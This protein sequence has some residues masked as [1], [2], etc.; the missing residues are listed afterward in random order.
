VILTILEKLLNI[1]KLIDTKKTR[2]AVARWIEELHIRVADPQNSVTTLSGG[3]QQRVVLAKWIAT[4]PKVLLLDSPTVG[5]D[6]AAKSGIYDIVK[7]LASEGMGIVLISDEVS[8]VLYN[9][10]RILLMRK[11]SI[12]GEFFPEHTTEPELNRKINED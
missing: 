12:V 7:Q 6:I 11:G 2:S 10:H 3:N 5:V 8:E 9:C 1:F 4:R